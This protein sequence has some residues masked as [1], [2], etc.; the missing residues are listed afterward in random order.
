MKL[1]GSNVQLHARTGTKADAVRK[2][3]KLLVDSGHVKPDCIDS[4]LGRT[5]NAAAAAG[6]R[7]GVCGGMAADPIGLGVTEPNV[8]IPSVAAL[9]AQLRRL[10]LSD[11]AS[12]ADKALACRN[13]AAVRRLTPA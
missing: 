8:G 9:E 6:I 5:V 4:I 1:E 3:G 10:A 13:A 12:L 7:V 2:V 11:A